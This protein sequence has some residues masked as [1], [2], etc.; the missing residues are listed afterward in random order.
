MMLDNRYFIDTSFVIALLNKHDSYHEKAKSLMPDIRN[1]RQIW[2]TE[3]ILTEIGNAFS[4]SK[5]TD[6][7]N[8]ITSC[9]CSEKFKVVTVTNVLFK[10]AVSLYRSRD[11]KEWGLTDCISFI[12]MQENGLSAAM[13][14]D[15]HFRQAGFIPLMLEE[16]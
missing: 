1:A 16:G 4:S 5:R 10:K 14:T 13:T 8:F 7:S 6:A 12:V 15:R 2:T 3:A 11:D 9:Y